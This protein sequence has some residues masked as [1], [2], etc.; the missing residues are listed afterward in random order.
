METLIA[1]DTAPAV[2]YATQRPTFTSGDLI[3][4]SHGDFKSWKGIK[5][6][7]VR[8]FTLSTYS[9]VGVIYVDPTDG[10][11]YVYEAV[12]P[13]VHRV[14]LSSIGSFYHLP[15]ERAAWTAETTAYADSI[16]GTE[17]SEWH[18]MLARFIT[19]PAGDVSE[20]AAMT[21]ELM[22]RAGVDL[23]PLSLPDH[24]IQRAMEMG[25]DMKFI[26]NP[27]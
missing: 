5:V 13:E 18:A 27:A 21:R 19:L 9:H 20:C 7:A 4:Q 25:A 23:G 6:L 14:R 8:L 12:K 15:M 1:R 26:V 2:P 10:H 16:L 3:A 11:V 24:V 22:L 17:Y